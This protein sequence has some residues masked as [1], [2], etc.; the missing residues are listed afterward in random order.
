M[1]VEGEDGVGEVFADVGGEHGAHAEFV[2][3]EVACEAADVEGGNGGRDGIG[4]ILQSGVGLRQ[5]AGDQA[6]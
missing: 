5:E 1:R 2:S 4:A 6:C 3:S